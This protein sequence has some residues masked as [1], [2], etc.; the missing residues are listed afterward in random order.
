MVDDTTVLN[1]QDL[2][3]VEY[4]Q[5]A[6]IPWLCLHCGETSMS[7]ECMLEEVD[8]YERKALVKCG[9]CG[10]ED[11]IH[12]WHEDK[13]RMHDEIQGTE[14]MLT[15]FTYW[16]GKNRTRLLVEEDQVLQYTVEPRPHVVAEDSDDVFGEIPPLGEV[17]ESIDMPD[18]MH[19]DTVGIPYKPNELEELE[20]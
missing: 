5:T 14:Y 12:L 3:Q 17:A 1:D 6:N 10:F 16:T 19:H 11:L 8:G 15:S 9:T 13:K 20:N 2:R 7:G 4:T 18:H